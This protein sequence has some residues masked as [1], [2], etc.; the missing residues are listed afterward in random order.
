MTEKFVLSE[1]RSFHLTKCR[2]NGLV[3]FNLDAC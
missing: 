1:K 2:G 3:N